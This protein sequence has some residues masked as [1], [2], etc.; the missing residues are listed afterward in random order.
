MTDLLEFRSDDG[1]SV[2]VEVEPAGSVTRGGTPGD[3]VVEAS[4]SLGRVLGKVGPAVKDI[5]AELRSRA[6]FP[7]EVEIEFTVKVAADSS[8]IIARA[9]GEAHFRIALR[10]SNDGERSPPGR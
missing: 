7:A 6:D 3:H 10:W 4:E 1:G 9:G 2:L 5:V 8:V